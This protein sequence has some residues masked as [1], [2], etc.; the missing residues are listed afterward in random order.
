MPRIRA[1]DPQWDGK[2]YQPAEPVDVAHESFVQAGLARPKPA[3]TAGRLV[4]LSPVAAVAAIGTVTPQHVAHARNL[5]EAIPVR[6]R[7]AA[8]TVR[9]APALVYGLLIEPRGEVGE[10]Q[11]ALLASHAGEET[12]RLVRELLPLFDR[13]GRRRPARARTARPAR[14]APAAPRRTFCFYR[15]LPGAHRSRPEAFLSRICAPT[16]AAPPSYGRRRAVRGGDAN[17]LLQ[18]RGGRDR[19]APFRAG[20]GRGDAGPRTGRRLRRGRP[21][22][23]RGGLPGRRRPAPAHRGEALAA[24]SRRVRIRAG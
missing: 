18:R 7:E 22:G 20:L 2:F 6:L 4:N 9:E 14:P 3:D 10:K 16:G 13:A 15:H 8:Q 5:L 17:L 19:R 21:A 1:V 23:R 11:A 24:Q 12:V